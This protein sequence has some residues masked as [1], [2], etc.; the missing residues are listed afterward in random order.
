MERSIFGL[1][2]AKIETTYGTDPTPVATANT[3]AITREGFTFSP[4]VEHLLRTLLDGTASKVSGINRPTEIDFSFTVEVRGNRTTGLVADIS[5]GAVANKIEIDPLL[6]AC[7]LDPTYTAEASLGARDGYVTYK[8]IV[9]TDEG[10]S[11]TVYFYTGT[12]LFKITACK[13]NVK[14]TLVAGQFGKLT[15]DMKGTFIPANISD[16]AIP[17]SITWLD[18]KPPLFASAASVIGS[19]S[20]IFQQLDFDLGNTVIRRDDA[21]A[22]YGVKGAL[23]TARNSKCSIDPEH[24]TE[25][26]HPIWGDLTASTARTIAATVG[27][28]AGNKMVATFAGVSE[29]I[30][31]GDR[32]GI[33]TAKIDYSIERANVSDA[34]N[35][36]F[37]LKFA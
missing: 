4:K 23:I 37:Q 17:G 29:A 5:A 25:A 3:I 31:L 2:L 11:C 26:T 18:T 27:S 7:D 30:S 21:N 33:R 20:P 34:A 14:G 35:S 12:K 36:E 15:F 24:V 28:L 10:K 8:P 9:P 22:A 32:A 1:V 13:G 16:A 19:Y 6:Q